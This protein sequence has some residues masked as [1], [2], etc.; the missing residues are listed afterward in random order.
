MSVDW[1]YVGP[2]GRVLRNGLEPMD[3]YWELRNRETGEWEPMN[4]CFSDGTPAD[5]LIPAALEVCDG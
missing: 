1:E 2:R 5:T 3:D 4:D